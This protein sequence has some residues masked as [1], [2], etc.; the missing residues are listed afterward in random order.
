MELS[1]KLQKHEILRNAIRSSGNA[2]KIFENTS[3]NARNVMQN[4]ENI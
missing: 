4:Q 3:Q 2:E 1:S